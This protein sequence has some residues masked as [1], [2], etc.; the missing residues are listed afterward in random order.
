MGRKN[1]IDKRIEKELRTQ[2][3]NPKCKCNHLYLEHIIIGLNVLGCKKC[4][5]MGFEE[6][7]NE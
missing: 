4:K 3:Y 7:E 5:C 2:I 1:R 6:V